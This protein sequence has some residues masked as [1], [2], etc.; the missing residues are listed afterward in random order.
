MP[1]GQAVH[2]QRNN[3]ARSCYHCCGGEAVSITYSEFVFVALGIK[4]TMRMRNIAICGL[5]RST[6]FF[7]INSQTA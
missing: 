3:E 5:P 6:T 2:V 1:T 7:H 4:H